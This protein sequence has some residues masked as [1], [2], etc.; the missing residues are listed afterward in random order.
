MGII[1]PNSTSSSPFIDLEL[2]L[3]LGTRIWLIPL[4]PLASLS[5]TCLKVKK[6]LMN[7]TNGFLKI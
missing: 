3:C 6:H 5:G 7:M 4:Y 2:S 1:A